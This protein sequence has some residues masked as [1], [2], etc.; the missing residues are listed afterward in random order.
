MTAVPK[1]APAM[2]S[3]VQWRSAITR[4]PASTPAAAKAA[5]PILRSS[6]V[7]AMAVAV[8]KAVPAWPEGNERAPSVPHSP[9]SPQSPGRDAAKLALDDFR[10]QRRR[11]D[12]GQSDLAGMLE[13]GVAVPSHDPA[14][15]ESRD[16]D[17]ALDAVTASDLDGVGDGSRIV[18][19]VFPDGGVERRQVPGSSGAG[20]GAQQP[21]RNRR[22]ESCAAADRSFP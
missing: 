8:A 19:G 7:Q 22:P 11:H 3:E 18:Q 14:Q 10:H 5:A 9:A 1:T 12:A 4:P 6:T 2:M 13:A 21:A 17:M 15:G 20:S 16:Q